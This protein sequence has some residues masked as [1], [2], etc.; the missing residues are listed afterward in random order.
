VIRVRA[1]GVNPVD[2]KIRA[3][4]LKC[5]FPHHLPLVPGWDAAGEVAAVGPAVT[6]FA[7]GDA[8]MVYAR[9]TT[10]SGAPTRNWPASA[11]RRSPTSP[12]R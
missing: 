11:R 1:A 6:R 3:G 4:Y 9:K 8:M 10:S 7:V 2:Y 5:A 12:T